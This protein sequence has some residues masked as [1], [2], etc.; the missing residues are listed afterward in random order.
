MRTR[1]LVTLALALP[2]ATHAWRSSLYPADWV[3]PST[4]SFYT[5]KFLQDY[6]YAGYHR[7]DKALP[8]V[9]SPVLNVLQAPFLA[10]SSGK[11]DATSAIQKAIDSAGKV[12]GGVVYLPKGTYQLSVGDAAKAALTINRSNIVLR[13]DGAGKTFLFNATVTMRSKVIVQ[14]SPATGSSW[15]AVAASKS[16][17]TGDLPSPTRTIPVANTSLFKVGDWVIVRQKMSEAWIAEHKETGWTGYA[18][19]FTGM[20]YCR[21]IL[22]IDL[23]RKTLEIDV[24]IRYALLMR[25]TA[26]VYLAPPMLEEVGIE[27][28][29]MGNAENPATTGWGENDY[30]VAGT[31]GYDN[32]DS[33]LVKFD[34][35]RNGW[36]RH[37]ESFQP[38]GNKTG[39]HLL[40]NGIQLTQTRGITVDSCHLQHSQYGGGGGNGYMYRVMGNENLFRDCRSTFTRHG[41]VL[42]DMLASGN[43]FLRVHDKDGGHQTGSTGNETTSGRGNDHH[44]HFS[45]S[46]L[47]DNCIAEN[48]NFQAA[49]RPYGTA[50]MHNLTAAHSAYWNTQGIGTD[51]YVIHTQQARYGYV[52][53]TRGTV[54][55]VRTTE[56]STGSATMT[57]PVDIVEGKALGTTLEPA[58]LYA[59]QLAKRLLRET[60]SNLPK[61]FTQTVPFSGPTQFTGHEIKLGDHRI[62]GSRSGR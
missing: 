58:S 37:V 54:T 51:P 27:Q 21:Q 57:D 2:L 3:P 48:T 56:A 20:V 49:Y 11:T 16:L 23:T 19:Q 1:P 33:W 42:A 34:R 38:L 50:P 53:G 13:G 17:V 60:T 22:S 6:S 30:T 32:H 61:P 31:G 5:D 28:L 62:D 59:D 47:F 24:P 44:M 43:V 10:D 25:D 15:S 39:A 8:L 18:N 36:I 35:V 4:D 7:S 14:V 41:F 46:N 52:V 45:H 55:E 29:S 26:K 9:T 40:S 12:G